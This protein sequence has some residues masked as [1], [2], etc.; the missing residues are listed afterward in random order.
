MQTLRLDHGQAI[1]HQA[2]ISR[3]LLLIGATAALV[4]FMALQD[5]NDKTRQ[6]DTD[7]QQLQQPRQSTRLRLD[8]KENVGKRDEILAV[9]GVM[10]ELALPWQPLFKT[11]ESL[12]TPDIK[13]LAVEPNPK[14]H[15]VRITAESSDIGHM[16]EYV[17]KLAQQPVLKD[18]FLL[19]HEHT[20]GGAMPIRFVVEAAWVQ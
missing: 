15:K 20:E 8:A 12:S 19:T 1:R 11:L 3:V 6:L 2:P 17:Q 5:I 14:Q 16:L 9:K 13:L 7:M 10:A 18:V 4:T